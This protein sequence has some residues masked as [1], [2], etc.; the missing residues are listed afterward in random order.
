MDWGKLIYAAIVGGI[1]FIDALGEDIDVE[2]ISKKAMATVAKN[3]AAK[4]AAEK[5]E[6]DVFSSVDENGE[7]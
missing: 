7:G 4:A 3:R 2:E 6:D 1:E 5:K